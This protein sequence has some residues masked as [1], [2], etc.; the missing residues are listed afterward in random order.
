MKKSD[1]TFKHS[2]PNE[3]C[4]G[5]LLIQLYPDPP[6]N[7]SW[8]IIEPCEECGFSDEDEADFEWRQSVEWV[9]GNVYEDYIEGLKDA[10]WESKLD[11]YR[12]GEAV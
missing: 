5:D 3:D 1:I 10:Y 12:D 2:C 7:N 4:E 8:S 11:A 6:D 9:A